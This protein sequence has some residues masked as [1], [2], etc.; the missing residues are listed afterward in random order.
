MS[1]LEDM[2]DTTNRKENPMTTSTSQLDEVTIAFDRQ[3]YEPCQAGTIGCCVDH[4]PH[5]DAPCE[6]W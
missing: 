1:I 5:K 2:G 4:D 3:E 6:A